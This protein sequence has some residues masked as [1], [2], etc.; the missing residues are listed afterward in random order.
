M[1]DLL[2]SESLRAKSPWPVSDRR[3][4]PMRTLPASPSRSEGA[5]S[6]CNRFSPSDHSLHP[7]QA[8]PLAPSADALHRATS[9]VHQW[10]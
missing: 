1:A 7:P 6:G 4:N 3:L 8:R 2:E 10:R 5:Q 9:R